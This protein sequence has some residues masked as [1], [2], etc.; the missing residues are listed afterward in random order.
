MKRLPVKELN[1]LKA[2]KNHLQT[3]SVLTTNPE[4]RKTICDILAPIGVVRI[5]SPGNMSRMVCG[6]AHDGTYAL[7]EYSRIVE[8]ELFE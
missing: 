8:T 5:T 3:A 2:Y 4:K 1:T 6:E 7:R